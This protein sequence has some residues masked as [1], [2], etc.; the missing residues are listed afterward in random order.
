MFLSIIGTSLNQYFNRVKMRNISLS[1]GTLASLASLNV[2]EL[3]KV[4]LIPDGDVKGHIK[5]IEKPR[6]PS[7]ELRPETLLHECLKN[8]KEADPFWKECPANGYTRQVAIVKREKFRQILKKQ[9]H[10]IK[11]WY[12]EQSKFWDRSNKIAFSKWADTNKDLCKQFCQ[13]FFKVLK[14]VLPEVIPKEKTESIL[15]KYR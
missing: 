3:E 1:A 6:F 5:R 4:I 12:K 10:G 8:L 14:R 11:N 9:K 13:E 2:P 15:K 7:G